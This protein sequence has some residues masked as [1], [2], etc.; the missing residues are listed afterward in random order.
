MK[1]GISKGIRMIF[2]ACWFVLCMAICEKTGA[3]PFIKEVTAFKKM[4]SLVPAPPNPILFIG[5]SSFTNWKDV[6]EYFPGYSILNR[7]FGGSSLTHLI[8][9]AED[10]I[11]RYHPGQVVIYCGE[12]D[13]AGDPKV[14]GDSVYRRFRRLFKMIRNRLSDIPIVYVSMKPS[15]SREKYLPEMI[16]GNDSI[17]KFLSK[18]RK[19][20]FVDV[21]H[22]MFTSDGKIMRD[23]FLNDNLHM[24]SKGYAIWKPLIEHYLIR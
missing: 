7:A 12:N 2:M 22:A 3:Q 18:K 15:P 16:K 14:D 24:N 19:T 21:Y 5:S 13:L 20:G 11:F 1:S 9:Y 23:I 10:V 8:T 17:R 4:D 6:R